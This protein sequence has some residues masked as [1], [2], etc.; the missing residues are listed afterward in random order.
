MHD[1]SSNRPVVDTWFMTRELSESFR[2]L[3]M[4]ITDI[5]AFILL[6]VRM[7]IR[8]MGTMVRSSQVFHNA[9]EQERNRMIRYAKRRKSE[10]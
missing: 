7:V 6:M 10:I 1:T 2:T 9:G 8:N 5:L 3:G 4:D